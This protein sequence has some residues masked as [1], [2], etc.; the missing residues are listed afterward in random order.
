MYVAGCDVGSLSAKAV[1]MKDTDI[2]ASRVIYARPEPEE[3]AREVMDAALAQAGITMREIESCVGTGYGRNSIPFAVAVESEIACHGKGARWLI[4][5]V[6]MVIDIGGQDAK[7]IRLDEQGNVARYAYNDKCASGTGR[8]LEIMAGALGVRI[9]DMG[10]L[11]FQ[12][13]NPVTISNQC[14]VFAETEIISLINDGRDLSDIM[15]GLHRAMAHR[16]ASLAKGI[17][18]EREIT[19]TGGVAKNIGMFRAL[20]EALG[21]NL[22]QMETDPQIIGALGAAVMARELAAGSS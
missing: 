1:I 12:A 8:F 15:Y 6:R 16:V 14:V 11:S 2:V 21:V 7:A 18:L 3:S 9:E 4:P 20:E 22:R 19:M 5:E 17:E 13:K 10:E